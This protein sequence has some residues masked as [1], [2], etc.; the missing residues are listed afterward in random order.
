M[1]FWAGHAL[2]WRGEH[3]EA[4]VRF[5]AAVKL[6]GRDARFWYFKGLTE[7]ALGEERRSAES[8]GRAV[9]LHLEGSPRADLIGIALERVQ[10][11]ERARLRLMLDSRRVSR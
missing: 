9:E 10:G 6:S 7:S 5:E 2:Y 4:L 11:A 1:L 8:L 3:E